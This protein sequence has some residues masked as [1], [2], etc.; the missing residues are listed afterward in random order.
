M[1]IMEMKQ[2]NGLC[3]NS[4]AGTRVKDFRYQTLSSWAW[5]RRVKTAKR[6]G[7]DE[8]LRIRQERAK[9]LLGFDERLVSGVHRRSWRENPNVAPLIHYAQG[10][11]CLVSLVSPERSRQRGHVT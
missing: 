11:V 6:G 8:R 5:E 4:A 3:A 7:C 1:D 9:P 10:V 2:G